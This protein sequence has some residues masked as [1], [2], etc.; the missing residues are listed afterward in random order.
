MS[1]KIYGHPISIPIPIPIRIIQLKVR[2]HRRSLAAS[3]ATPQHTA[4]DS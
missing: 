2:V 3:A 1:L 4:T